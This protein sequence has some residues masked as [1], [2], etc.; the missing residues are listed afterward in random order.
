M[1]CGNGEYKAT[2]MPV[3]EAPGKAILHDGLTPFATRRDGSREWHEDVKMRQGLQHTFQTRRA[4]SQRGLSG[5]QRSGG[6]RC[7]PQGST[8]HS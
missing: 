6:G 4:Q 3:I 1:C 7:S 5:V 8:G 2:V